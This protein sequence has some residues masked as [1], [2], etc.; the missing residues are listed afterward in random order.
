MRIWPKVKVH[1][2]WAAAAATY[3]RSPANQQ[4]DIF[5]YLQA[6]VVIEKRKKLS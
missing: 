4:S 6:S 2:E 5:K 3:S 1:S